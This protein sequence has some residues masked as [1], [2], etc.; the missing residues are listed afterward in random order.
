M[1]KTLPA[2]VAA[3]ALALTGCASMLERDYASASKHVEYPVSADSSIL[4][5]ESYQG[6]VSAILYFVSEH[7][8]TGVVHLSNYLG[9]VGADLDEACA[10]VAEQDPLGAYALNGITHNHTRIVSYYEVTFAFD[11]AHTAEEVAAIVPATGSQ[12]I[13]QAVSAALVRFDPVCVLR[14]S[15]FTGD[16]AALLAQTRQAWLNTPLAALAQPEVGVKLYPDSGTSRVAEFTFTWPG[17]TEALA[18]RA[19]QL[20]TAALLLLQEL[21]T[22]PEDL[23]AE[24]LLNALDSRMETGEEGGGTAYDALMEGRADNLGKTLALR[25]LCQLADLEATAVE[26]RLNGEARFWLIVSTPE[27]YR[28]LDPS[29]EERPYATDGE[30]A[31]LGYEWSADRYPDCIDYEAVSAGETEDSPET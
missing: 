8:P 17:D 21:D 14:L 24:M 31:A 29:A 28:H 25:L 7:A 1:K 5:A 2:L 23:T 27:G 13:F 16:E 19:A 3:L 15:Y 4:Q 30:F 12:A 9:D 18:A 10:E 22:P 11:Y 26:G 6:L 20:E